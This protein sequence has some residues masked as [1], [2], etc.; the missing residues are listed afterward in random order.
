MYKTLLYLTITTFII[1][2]LIF[3]VHIQKRVDPSLW[4]DNQ[5]LTDSEKLKLE[6]HSTHHTND[7]MYKLINDISNGESWEE[8]HSKVKPIK[9]TQHIQHINLEILEL[10]INSLIFV[11]GFFLANTLKNIVELY[12]PKKRILAVW[13]YIL[14][15]ILSVPIFA[16]SIMFL[17]HYLSFRTHKLY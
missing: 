6:I 2:F 8:A 16:I 13:Y 10:M 12:T 7:A 17:K 11:I 9:F 15:S 5:H 14:I 3:S 4:M 1:Y